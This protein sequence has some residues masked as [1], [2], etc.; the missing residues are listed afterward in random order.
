[1]VT[2]KGL[3]NARGATRQQDIAKRTPMEVLF[4]NMQKHNFYYRHTVAPANNQIRHLFWAHPVT[5]EFYIQHVDVLI[6]D[7]IY[8]TNRYNIS[9]S[10]IIAMTGM[11][12]ALPVAQCW[13]PG[14]VEDDFE[15]ALVTLDTFLRDNRIARPKLFVTDRDLDC[16]NAL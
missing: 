1:M 2:P 15:W 13:L 6:L 14:E 9:L 4:Q 16:R 3:S 7:C 8:K 5:K 11:N 10:N 12:T